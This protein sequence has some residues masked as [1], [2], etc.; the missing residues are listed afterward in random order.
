MTDRA[1]NGAVFFSLCI[2]QGRG[3]FRNVESRQRSVAVSGLTSHLGSAQ[4][5]S[6]FVSGGLLLCIYASLSKSLA[7]LATARP[8]F[9]SSRQALGGAVSGL[10]GGAW[11]P[12]GCRV[13]KGPQ[14][15]WMKSATR[16]KFVLPTIT[17]L[18]YHMPYLERQER[19]DGV[20]GSPALH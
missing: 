11:N 7:V 5:A 13:I 20:T 9:L 12:A 8:F 17:Y 18:A 19:R 15:F 10:S 3:R 4:G 16:Q 14:I 2:R 6:P 1:G